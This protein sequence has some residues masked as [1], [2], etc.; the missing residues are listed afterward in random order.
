[1]EFQ[2]RIKALEGRLESLTDSTRSDEDRVSALQ[3]DITSLTQTKDWYQEQLHTA[4]ENRWDEKPT[5]NIDFLIIILFAESAE[6]LFPQGQRDLVGFMKQLAP[7]SE[8]YTSFLIPPYTETAP[9]RAP[10][11]ETAPRRA[12]YTETAPRRAEILLCAHTTLYRDSSQTGRL[13]PPYTETAPRRADSY[14]LIPR[15]R[16][17]GQMCSYHLTLRASTH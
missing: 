12:P 5:G 1:V 10:Y 2:S 7:G 9:R 3:D 11:T 4:Q 16:P 17:D 15:Q 14:H 13:I 8:F 6:G